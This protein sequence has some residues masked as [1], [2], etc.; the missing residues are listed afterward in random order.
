MGPEHHD[1]C[2]IRGYRG[3][4]LG[5]ALLGQI[6]NTGAHHAVTMT[7]ANAC[8]WT[9]LPSSAIDA[10]GSGVVNSFYKWPYELRNGST[11]HRIT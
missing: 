10:F 11:T 6:R 4:T 8:F 2:G 9:V 7:D 5:P 1:P 3:I